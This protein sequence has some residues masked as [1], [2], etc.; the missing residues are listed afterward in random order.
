MTPIR[1]PAGRVRILMFMMSLGSLAPLGL[2]GCV[3]FQPFNSALEQQQVAAVEAPASASPTPQPMSGG[4]VLFG[5]MPPTLQV[6]NEPYPSTPQ[7]QHTWAG[8]GADFDPDIAPS[9]EHV[10]FASTRHARRP[11]IYMK[12]VDG[13]TVTQLT[14]DPSA[15][16]N[17]TFSP[18]GKR[19]AFASDRSGG[20]DIW[21]LDL[22]DQ[23]VT[24]IT[25]AETV[26][27]YPTWSPDGE[28]LAYCR[29]GPRS[30]EWE[31][32]TVTLEKEGPG[33]FIGY[34]MY[35]RWSPVEDALVFQ[36]PRRRG[37]PLFSIW[38]MKLHDGEPGY[39]TELSASTSAG[40][41]L[42]SWSPDGTHVAFCTV[43]VGG[44]VVNEE[45]RPKS[46]K[47]DTW[48]VDREG[49][50]RVR[51]SDGVGASYS[52]TW[53]PNGRIYFSSTR[54][55]PEN[56]WSVLPSLPT[57]ARASQVTRAGSPIPSGAGGG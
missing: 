29:L 20:F 48:I 43:E 46:A 19:I 3:I 42:P 5:S 18:D 24:Q 52:P 13:A 32:W 44:G 4:V 37:E 1:I 14:S 53:S 54:G 11:D 34:G 30:G 15:D 36:R 47:S 41:I 9:G 31:L 8:E 38:M 12:L 6:R 16:L 10:V 2:G 28:R 45:G 22:E 27:L 23:Q 50:G 33:N 26:E 39:A 40:F 35:P 21:V 25:H 55:G 51:V 17:P 49:R 57:G 56:I 7:I